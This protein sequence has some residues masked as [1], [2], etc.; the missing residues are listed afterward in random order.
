MTKPTNRQ[1]M[2]MVFHCAKSYQ[3]DLV[4]CQ[5]VDKDKAR[6]LRY[7]RQIEGMEKKVMGEASETLQDGM[8]GFPSMKVSEIRKLV[9]DGELGEPDSEGVIMPI[10]PS[11]NAK[12][13]EPSSASEQR[14]VL[15][16]E[17][18]NKPKS[19]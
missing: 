14:M 5:T 8:K 3:E 2:R 11:S 4:E 12:L 18:T 9:A 13:S 17:S 15:G 7:L 16:T 6:E 10:F 19:I 1:L